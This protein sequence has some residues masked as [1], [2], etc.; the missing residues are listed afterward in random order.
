[1]VDSPYEYIDST[2]TIV[3]DTSQILE[4]VQENYQAIL[5]QDLVTTPDTPQGVLITA[6]TLILSAVVNNN[7]QMANQ[8]NPNISGGVF[9]DGIMALTGI[10]RVAATY[11]LVT[12]VTL[13]GV[14]GTPIPAGSQAQTQA[15]DIFESV[16]SVTLGGGG[17]AIVNFQA[18]EAGPIPCAAN[19]L[20]IVVSNID[21]WETVVNNPGGSPASVT[22]IG[23]NTQSDQG[24]RAYRNNTIAFQGVA[25]ALAI[26]SALYATPGV[27]SLSFRENYESVP[28]GALISITGGAT[29]S[30][31]IWGMTTTAGTG[32]SNSIVIGTDAINFAVSLQHLPAISPWPAAAY[33][34]TGNITLSGLGTQGNGDW[35]GSLSAGQ[36]I[37]VLAQTVA[38][39]NGVYIAAAGSWSRQSFYSGAVSNI[40]GSND[41]I[42]MIKNSVYACVAGGTE[43]AVAAA[44]LENKSSGCAWNGNTSVSVVEPASGQSY[45]VLYDTPTL[46]C[47]QV[48]VT[49]TNG[50]ADNITQAILDYAVGN[51]N[52]FNG[53]IVGADVSAFDVAGAINSVYPSYYLSNV[54]ISLLSPTAFQNNPIPIGLNEQAYTQLSYISVVIT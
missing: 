44:L 21:G 47:I 46:I 42:S 11:T 2:G 15:G 16:G 18:V 17:T 9:Q 53:F 54:Q 30:G 5:G 39:Q 20:S 8:I 33:G 37:A 6:Q 26:T 38:S 25:L 31:Q 34:T 43:T 22:T 19:Q 7:A 50:N 13:A 10:Q 52:G 29:L 14:A 23:Q 1:M 24:A 40:L 12:N 32:A 3:P 4:G 41:G 28:M 35:T 51:L 27:T 36:I 49:T 45:S 48:K